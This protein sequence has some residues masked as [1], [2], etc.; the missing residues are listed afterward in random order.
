MT[1]PAPAP[2]GTI[3]T[4]RQHVV[5]TAI[6][7]L[8]VREFGYNAGPQVDAYLV[9]VRAK[10]GQHWCAAFVSWCYQR[11]GVTAP[12]VTAWAASYFPRARRL[13]TRPG[14]PTIAPQ[15]GDLIGLHY[16]NLKRIGHVGFVE[17]W[18]PERGQVVTIEGNTGADGSR[19]GDGVYRK[20]RLIRQVYTVASWIDDDLA[21][22][23]F[24]RAA[25]CG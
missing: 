25:R 7:Q 9:S 22:L 16:A 3:L 20:R 6:S 10:S 19:N 4:T 13:Y 18:R 23:T 14:A 24:R 17:R 8:G 1:P 15:P 5:A 11:A 12:P 2:A 21:T